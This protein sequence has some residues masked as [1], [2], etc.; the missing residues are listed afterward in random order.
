MFSF[1]LKFFFGD[2]RIFGLVC[3]STDCIGVVLSMTGSFFLTSQICLSEAKLKIQSL[4]AALF[5]S[6]RWLCVLISV[7]SQGKGLCSYARSSEFPI[8]S[9]RCCF[10]IVTCSWL[11]QSFLL[12]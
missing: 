9:M 12:R 6:P 8:C 7:L 4:G 3:V 10:T 1:D 11:L 2:R 5:H